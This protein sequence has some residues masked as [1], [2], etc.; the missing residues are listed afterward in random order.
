MTRE[1]FQQR[2][3]ALVAAYRP[4]LDVVDLIGRLNLLMVVG[5]SG[6]GKTTLINELS[7]VHVLSDNSR[8]PRE[9]EQEG[10]DFYF[11]NDYEQVV[12]E[13]QGGRFVQ[14][15]VDSGGDLKA[16]K[17]TSYPDE[18]DVVMAVLA[19]AVPTFRSLGFAR[20]ITAFITPPSYEEWMRRMKQHELKGEELARRLSEAKRSFSFALNDEQ[21]HFIFSKDVPTA[22]AQLNDL[23]SGKTNSALELNAR[24]SAEQIMIK[25]NQ[26]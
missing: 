5:P 16:T 24:I 7:L 8:P 1:E 18:G 17:A 22:V 19:D 14:V 25:L 13:I 21:T 20:T 9:G 4:A 3:P 12:K 15:V 23:L 2:L 6:V 11:R 26:D 10:V